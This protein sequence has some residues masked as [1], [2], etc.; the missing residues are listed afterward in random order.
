M[1]KHAREKSESN[2]DLL[3]FWWERWGIYGPVTPAIYSTIVIAWTIAW[4]ISC[5]VMAIVGPTTS[6]NVPG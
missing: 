3:V 6:E 5:I 1:K 2:S 4:T